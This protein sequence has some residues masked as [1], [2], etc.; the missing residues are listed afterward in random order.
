MQCSTRS[1][2]CDRC[3]HV[4]VCDARKRAAPSNACWCLSTPRTQ[5]N[6]H[7]DQLCWHQTLQTYQQTHP[8]TMQTYQQ[9]PS[10]SRT[11]P[12]TRHYF[13]SNLNYH[14]S[15]S[16]FPAG[17]HTEQPRR[18]IALARCF[19]GGQWDVVVSAGPCATPAP[20]LQHNGVPGPSVPVPVTERPSA[21]PPYLKRIKKPQHAGCVRSV[22]APF[23]VRRSE[24]LKRSDV[25]AN[26]F[27][28]CRRHDDT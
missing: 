21:P 25:G 24:S 2:C 18:L 1:S 13:M 26:D 5:K 11:V 16:P 9:D 19:T 20:F 4:R 23:G 14:S 3:C 27:A 7:V 8:A 22:R 10:G 28:T 6:G 12:D 17:W 15:P